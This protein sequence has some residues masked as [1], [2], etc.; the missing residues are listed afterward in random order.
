MSFFW[1]KFASFYDGHRWFEIAH[2]HDR[3]RSGYWPAF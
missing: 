3:R 2:G 1:E